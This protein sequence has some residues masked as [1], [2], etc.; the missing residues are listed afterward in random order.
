[1]PEREDP[2][3]HF[4]VLSRSV[5]AESAKRIAMIFQEYRTRFNPAQV[6][7]TGLQHAGTAA[8][9]LVGEITILETTESYAT[10]G[11]KQE[12]ISHLASLRL[13]LG[14]MSRNYQPAVLMTHV[15]DQFI[16]RV[17][18]EPQEQALPGGKGTVRPYDVANATGDGDDGQEGIPGLEKSRRKKAKVDA[19]PASG[20]GTAPYDETTGLPFL[21]SSF[22]EDLAGDDVGFTGFNE[23]S[24]YGLS[25]DSYL[26]FPTT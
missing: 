9:A 3:S 2:T 19:G 4:A 1:M 21:P 15:V 22:L 17:E 23:G 8:T 26:G 7:E 14:M 24:E 16:K 6:F 5:C 10:S 18:P 25:W 13:T 20:Q 11:A 12:V